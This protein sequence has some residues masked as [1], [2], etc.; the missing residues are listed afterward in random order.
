MIYGYS[1]VQATEGNSLEAQKAALTEAGATV[2]YEETYTGT[3]TERPELNKLI[4]T[5]RPGDT[6]MVTK[7]DRIARSARQGLNL[8]D[9]I[10]KKDVAVRILNM[11]AI[12]N[13]PI[14]RLLRTMMLGFAEFEKDMIYERTMEGRRIA[15]QNPG[16]REGRPLKY[17][18][19]Q[20]EHALSLLATHSFRQVSALTG[21]SLAT[22]KRHSKLQKTK[23]SET[24]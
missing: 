9:Q 7:L 8:I 15:R 12:D 5:L 2:I 14:G 11:G 17:S 22:L 24:D 4:E 21:I 19:S 3:T 6:L 16:Y 18:Q 10:N 23:L 1:R 20:M 13:T